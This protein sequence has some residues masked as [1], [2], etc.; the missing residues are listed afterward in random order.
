ML[1]EMQTTNVMQPNDFTNNDQD[2]YMAIYDTTLKCS[3][4]QFSFIH[5]LG[6]QDKDPKKKLS[7]VEQF[8]V[9]CDKQSKQYVKTQS[10]P[11]TTINTLKLPAS[12]PHLR[13]AGKTMCHKFLP[14]LCHAVATL[15]YCDYL[16]K[17]LIWTNHD[18]DD[19]H[20]SVLQTTLQLF[21]SNDQCLL[22]LFI[23]DKL[24][25]HASLTN[26]HSGSPLCPSCQ[27]D[28]EDHWHFLECTHPKWNT[29]FTK[30][31]SKLSMMTQKL[32]LQPSISTALW[33]GLASI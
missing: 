6:H 33:L 20:W 7:T 30:L 19:V 27:R 3:L 5:V 9:D 24:P 25:L 13:I 28:P 16:F 31:K 2:I 11:S 1:T 23:N 22:I 12:Q 4:L 21:P 14:A 26:P 32:H 15:A 8:N 10:S 29:L 18:A 17:K